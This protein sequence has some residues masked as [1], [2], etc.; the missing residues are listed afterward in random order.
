ME[1][2]ARKEKIGKDFEEAVS[3]HVKRRQKV[4]EESHL[5]MEEK[6]SKLKES[7][8]GAVIKDIEMIKKK[9]PAKNRL[10]LFPEV[11]TILHKKN[12]HETL[13]DANI[14]EEVRYWLEPLGF[15]VFPCAEIRDVLIR[16]MFVLPIEKDHLRESG[17][18]KIVMF[19]SKTSGQY[20][21]NTRKLAKK[22][23]KKWLGAFFIG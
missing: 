18:G 22:L 5:D 8:R 1:S 14:L 20:F 4:K 10:K 2:E 15:E 23:I 16:E 13:L 7:M 6:I 21:S 9:K 11:I 12:F 3:E 17:V 19:Y